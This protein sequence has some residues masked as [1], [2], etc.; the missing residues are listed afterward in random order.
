MLQI[1]ARKNELLASPQ[2]NGHIL[3]SLS[4]SSGDLDS[5]NLTLRRL[6]STNRPHTNTSTSQQ[7]ANAQFTHNRT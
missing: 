4:D 7:N 1:G 3:R 6:S 2:E 5:E